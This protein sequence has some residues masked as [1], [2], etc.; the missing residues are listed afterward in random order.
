MPMSRAKYRNGYSIISQGPF[1]LVA[2][3]QPQIS[4]SGAAKNHSKE[5]EMNKTRVFRADVFT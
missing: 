2:K 5:S 4:N 1:A 3:K